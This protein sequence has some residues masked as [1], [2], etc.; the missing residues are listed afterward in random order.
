MRGMKNVGFYS[1]L[2]HV[3]ELELLVAASNLNYPRF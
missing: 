2:A 1:V 3:Q